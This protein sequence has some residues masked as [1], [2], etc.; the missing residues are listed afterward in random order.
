M[1]TNQ[2]LP[3]AAFVVA[4]FITL[5]ALLGFGVHAMQLHSVWW[6]AFSLFAAI[7][8]GSYA[9]AATRY[10]GEYTDE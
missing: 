9:E 2:L 3:I 10:Y 4:G 6:V 1:I 8:V 5:Y 7:W